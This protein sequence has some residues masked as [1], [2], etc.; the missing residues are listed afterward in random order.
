[1]HHIPELRHRIAGAE[2]PTPAHAARANPQLL[3]L[4]YLRAVA[5]M[6]VVVFHALVQVHVLYGGFPIP[7]FGEVGVDIFFVLSGYVMWHSTAGRPLSGR[8]FLLKRLI[9]IAPLYW[10][11]TLAAVAATLIVPAALNSTRFDVAHILASL[12]FVPWPNPSA[13][14]WL[15]IKD[16]MSPLIVPGWTLNMEMMFYL[17]FAAAIVF[18]A[19]MRAIAVVG[20]VALLYG[21]A[22][23]ASDQSRQLAFYANDVIFEFAAGTVLAATFGNRAVFSPKIGVAV[24]VLA[25]VALVVAD[26]MLMPGPRCLVFGIP[27]LL[28]VTSA[29]AVERAM[30]AGQHRVL[31]ELGDASY[32]IYLSHIF[33][34]AL[35]R[36][37]Y[38][39]L[40]VVMTTGSGIAFVILGCILSGIVGIAVHRL[41]EKRLV[42]GAN[43]LIRGRK[44]RP[45]AAASFQ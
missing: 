36:M 37:I 31:E 7:A 21:V 40:D 28:I 19:R 17:L 30:G 34:I 26:I 33:V 6:L 39:G 24:L 16:Q 35:L 14:P 10:A 38:N 32:S 5:A 42:V 13:P 23:A 4:Q 2:E 41:I 45:P 44:V 3:S 11:V 18:P 22:L 8:D 27:A 25:S 1:M 20:L 12:M 9:R 15:D 29:L 43:A